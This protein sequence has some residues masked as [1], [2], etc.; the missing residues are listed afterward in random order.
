MVKCPLCGG[1]TT[2]QELADNDNQHCQECEDAYDSG[3][4]QFKESLN[5]GN[6]F[7]SEDQ[8]MQYNELFEQS[9]KNCNA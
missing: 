4:D 2:E 9:R 8:Y 7:P 1:N 6:D 5:I 3:L